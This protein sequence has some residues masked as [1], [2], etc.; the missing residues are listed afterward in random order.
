MFYKEGWFILFMDLITDITLVMRNL[1]RWGGCLSQTEWCFLSCC[2]SLESNAV[3]RQVIWS[4]DLLLFPRHIRITL[5]VVYQTFICQNLR[6]QPRHL[7]RWLASGT[8]MAFLLTLRKSPNYLFLNENC[9][10]ICYQDIIDSLGVLFYP[11]P[12]LALVSRICF[13]DF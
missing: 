11:V 5:V 6:L 10:G 7:S 12:N 4:R 9:G 2:T 1:N 13:C 3:W 8:G